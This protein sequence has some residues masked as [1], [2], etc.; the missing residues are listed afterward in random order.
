MMLQTVVTVILQSISSL[1]L[2]LPI[3]DAS[4]FELLRAFIMMTLL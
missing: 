2:F 3:E 4:V 1:T